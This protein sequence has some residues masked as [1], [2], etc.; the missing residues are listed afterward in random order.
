M[1]A[2]PLSTNHN[3]A[4]AGLPSSQRIPN[5][6]QPCCA[7]I[8]TSPGIKLA[9]GSGDFQLCEYTFSYAMMASSMLPKRACEYGV[10]I[11]IRQ[12]PAASSRR[13]PRDTL[14]RKAEGRSAQ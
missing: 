3:C 8:R 4:A 5:L 6:S 10:C 2:L 12:L 9:Q 1:L 7:A 14:P 13:L 11:S